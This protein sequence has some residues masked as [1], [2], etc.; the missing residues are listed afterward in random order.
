MTRGFLQRDC[1]GVMHDCYGYGSG[2]RYGI[3]RFDPGLTWTWTLSALGG[4]WL[5]ATCTRCTAPA[6]VICSR[7]DTHKA[8]HHGIGTW[9]AQASAVCAA[10]TCALHSLVLALCPVAQPPPHCRAAAREPCPVCR[11][12]ALRGPWPWAR[13][14]APR[15]VIR[16]DSSHHSARVSPSPLRQ[17]IQP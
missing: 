5:L 4:D 16:A 15:R 7:R 14:V 9:L 6:D 10:V 12:R 8:L 13:I 3:R 1:Y 2:C 11:C 17:L